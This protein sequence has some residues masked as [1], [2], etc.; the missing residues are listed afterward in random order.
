MS[1]GYSNKN[2]FD[3]MN[4]YHQTKSP[5]KNEKQGL[6]KMQN[7]R[8]S[9]FIDCFTGDSVIAPITICPPGMNSTK[10]FPCT[11]KS[12]LEMH[13]KVKEARKK[14]NLAK[15]NVQKYIETE[16][17]LIKSLTDPAGAYIAGTS[18]YN[19]LQKRLKSNMALKA[20]AENEV[21]IAEN[22]LSMVENKFKVVQTGISGFSSYHCPPNTAWNMTTQ[23]CESFGNRVNILNPNKRESI[24][25]RKRSFFN[26]IVE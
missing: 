23:K 21:V 22:N 3:D 6:V 5:F 17:T 20:K 16:N 2:D 11:P 13:P 1:F 26:S 24:M 4:V 10:N 15:N 14:L 25:N 9:T 8:R 18:G 7:R 12:D 19:E